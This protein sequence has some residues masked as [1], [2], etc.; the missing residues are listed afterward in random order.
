M[1]KTV[2]LGAL[3]SFAVMTPALAAPVASAEQPAEQAQV[4]AV[5]LYAD[6]C[7][8]CK[9]LD[10]KLQAARADNAFDGVAFEVIDYTNRDKAA[11]WANAEAM[12]VSAALKEAIGGRPKTGI[13]VLVDASTDT[14][15]AKFGKAQSSDDMTALIQDAIAKTSA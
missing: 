7:S 14:L 6:W 2:A 9:A 13:V 15:I 11:F 1:L 4:V 5:A 3:L 10:P 8:S 12:G